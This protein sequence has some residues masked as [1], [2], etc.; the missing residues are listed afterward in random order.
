MTSPFIQMNED[1]RRASAWVQRVAR[2]LAQTID[3]PG[4]PAGSLVIR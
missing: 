3:E 4:Q 1:H 2:K